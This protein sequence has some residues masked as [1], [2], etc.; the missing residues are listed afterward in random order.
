MRNPDKLNIMSENCQKIITEGGY[1]WD[2]YGKRYT[3]NIIKFIKKHSE[4]I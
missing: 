3:Q 4:K 1:S 2:D